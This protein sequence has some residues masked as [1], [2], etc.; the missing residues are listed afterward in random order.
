MPALLGVQYLTHM[1]LPSS[2]WGMMGCR[3]DM[4]EHAR[5]GPHL[6][7]ILPAIQGE[8][9]PRAPGDRPASAGSRSLAAGEQPHRQQTCHCGHRTHRTGLP[10]QP[11]PA[12]CVGRGRHP[13][14]PA[15]AQHSESAAPAWLKRIQATWVSHWSW[16]LCLRSQTWTALQQRCSCADRPC[17]VSQHPSNFTG[18]GR[19]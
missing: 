9:N 19:W 13:R 15:S 5:P 14:T 7:T 6:C 12:A 18:R 11:R 1:C 4:H 2:H 10:G 17:P 3:H 16:H 8:T